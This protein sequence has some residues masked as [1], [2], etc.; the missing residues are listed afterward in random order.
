MECAAF[1]GHAKGIGR[2]CIYMC[3]S[4]SV[5]LCIVA[6]NIEY[7]HFLGNGKLEMYSDKASLF[8]SF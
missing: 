8:A 3:G 1:G 5:A 7:G 4:A 6:F 2:L